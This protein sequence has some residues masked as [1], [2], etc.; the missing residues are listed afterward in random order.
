MTP[1]LLGYLL[2]AAFASIISVPARLSSFEH[3][4][5]HNGK[6]TERTGETFQHPVVQYGPDLIV[7]GGGYMCTTVISYR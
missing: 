6:E 1:F 5:N 7:G 4:C 3:M 2:V